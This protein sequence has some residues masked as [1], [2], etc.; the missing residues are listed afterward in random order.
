MPDSSAVEKSAS[1]RMRLADLPPSSRKTFFTVAAALAMMRRPVCVEPVNDT[2]ST[3]GSATSRSEEHTSELQSLM[4]N[5]YAVFC[6]I[7]KI[8]SASQ[9]CLTHYYE[10]LKIT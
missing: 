3:R 6:V 9:T 5:S 4:R 2:M 10:L 1:S 7:T 8:H